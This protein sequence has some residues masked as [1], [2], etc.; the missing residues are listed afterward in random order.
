M[1]DSGECLLRILPG[2]EGAKLPGKH[3]WTHWGV[4]CGEKNRTYCMKTWKRD[5]PVC[6]L[7][8]EY[9]G[10]LELAEW[11]ARATASASLGR[12]MTAV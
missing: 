1:P 10:R 3:I 5:C 11:A 6:N 2:W 9:D 4:N 12:A 7:L 8:E